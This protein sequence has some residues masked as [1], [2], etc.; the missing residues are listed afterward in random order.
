MSPQSTFPLRPLAGLAGKLNR[1]VEGRLWLKVVIGMVLGIATG[2][3]LGPGVGWV[4]PATSK[5]IVSWLA[6]PG[7]IF[8]V[9]VQMIVVPL[10]F[11]SIV[12]GLAGSATGELKT[13]GIGGGVFFLAT[14]VLATAIGLGLALFV[15]PG[16]YIDV[17]QVRASLGGS[18]QAVPSTAGAT[19]LTNVPALLISLLP[20][21]PL[22]AMAE[23]QMLQVILFAVIVG[24]AL[25]NM[26]R[27]KSAP[28]FD[29]LGSLLEVCMTVVSWAMRLA[30]LAVFGLMSRLVATIGFGVLAGMAVYVGTV[31]LGLL[32]LVFLYLAL[33]GG[34]ARR[35]PL[36]FLGATRELLLLAFSTSS[37]AAVMPLSIQTAEQKLGVRSG[38]ARLLVPLGATVNMNGTALYQG[39]ATVFLATAFGIGLDPGALLFVVSM[40]VVAAIGSPGTPGAGIVILA[41]VLEGVGIPAAGVALILGVDRL[42]DMARTAVNVAGDMT[43]CVVLDRFIG[44][45]AAETAPQAE[46]A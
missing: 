19:D 23:G 18:V 26:P 3:L 45:V 32:L 21:N 39:V 13:L 44:E 2:V 41:A 6:L 27:D 29:L 33:V 34:L 11:A 10:V 25:V 30:P 4:E 28:L 24:V 42:L 16:A 17:A 46:E 36:A 40:A 14:T 35:S 43:A 38:V 22:D 1:L 37:S 12:R 9:L 7:Q 20:T 5:T 15:D 8:L 31:L